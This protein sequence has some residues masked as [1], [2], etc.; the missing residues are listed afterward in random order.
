LSR[1]IGRYPTHNK[2]LR[3][4]NALSAS[5]LGVKSLLILEA[6]LELLSTSPM[7][8]SPRVISQEALS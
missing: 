4:V 2:V 6:M 3:S 5:L 1:L 7:H 8:T